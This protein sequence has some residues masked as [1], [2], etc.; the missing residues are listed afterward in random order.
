MAG[1]DIYPPGFPVAA[2][3][4]QPYSNADYGIDLDVP[5]YTDQD[6]ARDDDRTRE[7]V[8]LYP[9]ELLDPSA[10]RPN[11]QNAPE[12]LGALRKEMVRKMQQNGEN[13]DWSHVE[14][15]PSWTDPDWS[16]RFVYT[17][18]TQSNDPLVQMYMK[19]GDMQK[20]R[21]AL[22]PD[23]IATRGPTEAAKRFGIDPAHHHDPFYH[24]SGV[25]P[26]TVNFSI[27]L[28]Y[29][30]VTPSNKGERDLVDV[31]DLKA[32]TA[33][34][35]VDARARGR[36]TS[37]DALRTHLEMVAGGS[38]SDLIQV[39][40]EIADSLLKLLDKVAQREEQEEYQRLLFAGNTSNE[41]R[42][43]DLSTIWEILH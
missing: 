32:L 27:P 42:I 20:Q 17:G 12:P 36:D 40:A 14:F 25:T 16:D 28:G 35:E 5:D 9:Y 37:D 33:Q 39:D 26:T 23:D 24:H 15:V 11:P 8:S 22:L 2:E 7:L 38:P 18:P 41:V 29:A 3:E 43:C 21:P 6:N 10:A 13:G 4:Y 31:D 19:R 34:F 30:R 1:L